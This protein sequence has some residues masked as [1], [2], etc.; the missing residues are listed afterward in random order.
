MNND[1]WIP[2]GFETDLEKEEQ[3]TELAEQ[4]FGV[5]V[6][7]IHL[8]QQMI[9][10]VIPEE[11][12]DFYASLQNNLGKIYA[13]LPSD[14][15]QEN[16]KLA[17]TCYENA[18]CV[19][20]QETAPIE[21]A[22]IQSN[23]GEVYFK[24]PIGDYQENILKS[25]AC[26]Q[27]ALHYQQP[28]DD[29][30]EYAMNLCH[31]GDG[32][33]ALSQ[34]LS[35]N[36]RST[37]LA[38]A[39]TYYESA[40]NFQT[41]EL[42]PLGYA[43]IQ[44]SLGNAYRKMLDGDRAEHLNQAIASYEEA[45]KVFT[46]TNYPFYYAMIQ[47]NLG[48]TYFE[49]LM[50][51]RAMNLTQ[52]IQYFEEA[53]LFLTLEQAPLDCAITQNNLGNAYCNLPSGNHETNVQKAIDCYQQAL[54]FWMLETAPV[55]YAMAQNNLGNAYR[56]LLT[57]NHESNF[58]QA[59]ECYQK[60]LYVYTPEKFPLNYAGVQHNLGKAYTDLLTGNRTDNLNKAINYYQEALRFRTVEVAPLEYAGLQHALGTAY[61]LL[62]TGEHN[63][64]LQKAINYYQ[65]A[66]HY[67]T[68]ETAPYYF[69]EIQT[70]LG[71]AYLDLPT[72]E[73]GK[74]ITKAMKCFEQAL[75]IVTPEKY[76]QLYAALQNQLG[77]VYAHLPSGDHDVNLKK[78]MF[79]YQDALNFWSPSVSPLD[80]AST[81]NNLGTVYADLLTG[82]RQKNLAK[83]IEC[84][85][86]AL[87]FR[88]L[89]IAPLDYAMT[90]NN[91]GTVY[92]DLYIG[93]REEK[94]AQQAITSYKEALRVRTPE[95]APFDYAIT[96]SNLAGIYVQLSTGEPKH[97]MMQAIHHA[98]EALQFQSTDTTP[99]QYAASQNN[100]GQAYQKLTIFQNEP[101]LN[102]AIECYQKARSIYTLELAPDE[103]RT[104]SQNIAAL[105]FSKQN[106]LLALKAYQDAIEAGERLYHA[107]LFSE[108]K[109]VEI[110]INVQLYSN[111][112]FAT[113]HLGDIK[114]ALL[115][116]EQGKTRLLN[117]A[118]QMRITRP[119][120]V[121]DE[122]WVSFEQTGALIKTLPSIHTRLQ[123]QKNNLLQAYAEYEQIVQERYLALTKTIHKVREYVPNFLKPIDF[124]KVRNAIPNEQTALVAFCITE[125]GSIVFIVTQKFGVQYVN[126]PDFTT[127][128]LRVL[129]QGAD[130]NPDWGGWMELYDSDDEMC[131]HT[132]LE[133]TLA[134]LGK[135]LLSPILTQ[136][137]THITR[138]IFLLSGQLFLLPLHAAILSKEPL[139]RVCDHYQVT[140]VP[141]LE[142]L[143]G[144]LEKTKQSV[145]PCFYA[146]LNPTRDLAY[147][148][149]EGVA[150]AEFFSQPKMDTEQMGTKQAVI[151]G[152]DGCSYVHFSCHGYY[153]WSKPM[154]SG[155]NLADSHLTLV[156]LQSEA[157]DLSNTRLVTLS[158]C[159]TGLSD[160][161][162]GSPAEFIGLPA[163]FMLAGV[164]C[165]VSSLW[166]VPELSTALLME[167]FYSNHLNHSM[168]F[169]SALQEAQRWVFALSAEQVATY[170]EHAY[171][172]SARN[173]KATVLKHLRHYR[174][175]AENEPTIRPFEHPYYWAAFTVYGT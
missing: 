161:L 165:V 102:Q 77:S 86:E 89:E 173:Y 37:N 22:L 36:E 46:P 55:D 119:M 71:T 74:N 149:I 82:E 163:G 168:D 175:L 137:P 23:L 56:A 162:K 157:V 142:V 2:N 139:E 132:T 16:L 41:L 43:I 35:V 160:V 28:K 136:C 13:G 138:L 141:S 70:N 21:Y 105:Y 126:V 7:L 64:N 124:K 24:M 93:S 67:R 98:Q 61:S 99:I 14:D 122:V 131:Q 10:R 169:A 19:W 118:L 45:L 88:T 50:G 156:E 78:A 20:T 90:Q 26:Y 129:T 69:A 95:V 125:Q 94:H 49:S 73:H 123:D 12:P 9:E 4:D 151:T 152:V 65:E 148:T 11:Y 147:A 111:A 145:N 1:N 42:E 146:V 18:L 39:I 92:Y 112:T 97:N 116:L 81:Q 62:P 76:P 40:L 8:Y 109:A 68:L 75:L 85:Q 107:G 58:R 29:P 154:L 79:C 140:Y 83:A 91:L 60:A 130:E 52:A 72:G 32:Y 5:R 159:E 6:E 103:Y 167:R 38:K 53:L 3:L 80:Y 174:Y 155:L 114:R 164:P 135:N 59:I 158:A 127:S 106:W 34:T 121:P 57:G 120:L 63:D 170:A 15:L 117:E 27:N 143:A 150:I 47:G 134:E 108:S 44:N 54:R 110:A 84:F 25:I 31:L 128:S 104:I 48:L 133:Q 17:I 66:L 100:L 30:F 153:N 144:N 87:H 166:A 33:Q 171:Q 96:H 101:Y 172:Q 115:I 113:V 51:D